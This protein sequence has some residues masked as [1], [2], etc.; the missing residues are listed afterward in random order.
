MSDGGSWASTARHVTDVIWDTADTDA[1]GCTVSSISTATQSASR[2]AVREPDGR[3]GH[4]RLVSGLSD[5]RRPDRVT[6]AV[7]RVG[8]FRGYAG[9]VVCRSGVVA[10]PG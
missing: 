4:V 9:P 6:I 8:A 7:V 3:S 1:A 2:H 5:A 10:R